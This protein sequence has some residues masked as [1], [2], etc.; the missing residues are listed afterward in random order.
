MSNKFIGIT[1][2]PIVETLLLT[3]KPAGLWGASYIFSYFS[4]TLI[5]NLIENKNVKKEDFIIPLWT[6]EISEKVKDSQVGLLHDRIIFRTNENTDLSAIEKTI[7]RTKEDV[8]K[9]IIKAFDN[10]NCSK[11]KTD[12]EEYI[13]KYIRTHTVCIE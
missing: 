9:I 4:K 10:C 7:N 13:K 8:A 6:G 3:T 5:E 1:V 11:E 12:V 2:G